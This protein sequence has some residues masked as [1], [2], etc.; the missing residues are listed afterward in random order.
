MATQ[1][2]ICNWASAEVQR[3]TLR[4]IQLGT[5]PFATLVSLL[6]LPHV[7]LPQHLVPPD[8]QKELH[9]FLLL[10]C[11]IITVN[12]VN[13]VCWKLTNQLLLSVPLSRGTA[14]RGFIGRECFEISPRLREDIDTCACVCVCVCVC[15]CICVRQ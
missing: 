4:Q 3:I 8:V 6:P 7:P 9:L 10:L 5:Y 14:D 1:R 15:V 12:N 2:S 13:V 11:E